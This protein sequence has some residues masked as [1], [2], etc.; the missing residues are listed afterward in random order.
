ME[1]EYYTPTTEA[2]DNKEILLQQLIEEQVNNRRRINTILL[3]LK[4]DAE[5]RERTYGPVRFLC[6]VQICG[7][8]AALFLY[9][10]NLL[11]H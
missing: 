10:M 4:R 11:V 6:W 5:N 7:M 8:I 2:V 3:Q 9:I 1:E